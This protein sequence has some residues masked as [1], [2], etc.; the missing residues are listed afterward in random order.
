M[1]GERNSS[2]EEENMGVGRVW[3]GKKWRCRVQRVGAKRRGEWNRVRD[4]IRGQDEA[5]GER[6]GEWGVRERDWN[7]AK[8]TVIGSRTR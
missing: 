7:G 5:R 1:D 6:I 2:W 3:R 4:C 8:G